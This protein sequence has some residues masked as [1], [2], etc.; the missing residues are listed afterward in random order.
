MPF[1]DGTFDVVFHQ[2]LLEHFR[3]PLPLLRENIRVLK[4]GGFLVVDV[5]QTY[6]YYTLGKQILIALDRWFAG[7]ETQFTSASWRPGP[8]RGLQIVRSYGDWMVPGLWYRALRKIAPD[9]HRPASAHV[10]RSPLPPLGPP[11]RGLARV[12]SAAHGWACTRPPPSGS[13]PARIPRQGDG[14][15]VRLLAVNWRDIN[16]PLGG[17]AEIH[18]HQILTGAVAAGWEVDLVCAGYARRP[19]PRDHRR[20]AHPPARPLG[21]G[22]LRVAAGGAASA[23]ARTTTIC[24][25]RTSTRSPSTRRCTAGETPVLAI[26]PHLFG[27]TVF[28][29]ANPLL[30][31]YVYAAERLIPL[32]YRDVDFEVI[33]PSTRDDLVARGLNRERVRT[34]YCGLDHE[35]FELADPPPR[36]ETPL[37]VTWSRLRRYKSID[38]AIT[39]LRAHPATK[40][41]TRAC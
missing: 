38:V 4:P 17:G 20:R 5:P 29:E 27:T 26:V 25:S 9:P 32:V 30:A 35:R 3:D 11:G 14:S 10:S 13:W 31:T 22:Q 33:S 40:F 7:W 8:Q 1:A 23:A 24:W 39:R 28:R 18:L 36:S 19:G 37:V 12:V 2:G 16:D 6:H 15:S 21:G 41:P 34:I